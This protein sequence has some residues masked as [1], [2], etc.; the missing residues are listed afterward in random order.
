MTRCPEN[1]RIQDFLD[2]ELSPTEAAAFRVH[3][4]ACGACA[5]EVALFQRVFATLD[6][7]PLFAPPPALTERVLAHVLPSSVRRRR[8]AVL[9]W[10]Y[11]GALTAC[12]VSLGFWAMQPG[13][14]VI[15]EGA[16]AEISRRLVGSGLFVLNALGTS[17]VRLADGWGLLHAVGQRVAPLSRAL[18]AVL[19]QPSISLTVWAAAA[20]CAAL[21]WWM[22]PRVSHAVRGVRHVGVLGF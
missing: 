19:E 10:G 5:G 2:G 21:L 4:A 7:P 3:L 8:L 16:S 1:A 17:A 12:V 13:S 11:A 22:R 15:L 6:R 18:T 20:A 9:G 14:R